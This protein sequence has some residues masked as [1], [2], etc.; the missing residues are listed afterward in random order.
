MLL[1]T[2]AETHSNMPEPV[3][4]KL[5]Q[6]RLKRGLSLDEV[7]HA[8]K[9]RPEK[10]LALESDDYTGFPSNAYVKGFLKNY[11][12]YLGVDVAA[13][14]ASIDSTL[15]ITVA[16]Y[17]YLS[18]A[19]ETPAHYEPERRERR[20]PSVLPIIAAAAV[21]FLAVVGFWIY[22]NAQRIFGEPTA[23]QFTAAP[24]SPAP[25][26]PSVAPDIALPA[27]LSLE[28]AAPHESTAEMRPP[29]PATDDHA[30]IKPTIAADP[31]DHD[32]VTPLAVPT[33]GPDSG[34]ALPSGVNEVLVASVKKTWI[35]VRR[36]DPKAPPIFEDFVYPDTRPLKVRGARL[37]I[38]ARDPAAVQLTKNGLPIAFQA[39][40]VPIQ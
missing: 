17:Q 21:L 4:K 22:A 31:A 27:T 9:L 20:P 15:P 6:A 5:A 37:F 34:D 39:P 3:G 35:T 38:E 40:G 7:A 30:V 12:R 25:M 2:P 13:V 32:I 16:E 10:I 33:A 11:A 18:N 19:P 8:T 23:P 14:L 24:A 36:D 29:A 28:P 26:L 1:I